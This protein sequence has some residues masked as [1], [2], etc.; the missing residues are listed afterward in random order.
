MEAMPFFC[1]FAERCEA[2]GR[3]VHYVYDMEAASYPIMA[4]HGR[5]DLDERIQGHPMEIKGKENVDRGDRKPAII[6]QKGWDMGYKH[7]HIDKLALIER[8]RVR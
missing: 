5:A 1:E 6:P 7:A 3:G 8:N 2:Y 4:L